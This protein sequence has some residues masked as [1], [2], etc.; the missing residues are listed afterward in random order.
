MQTALALRGN[1]RTF[2][3][4]FIGGGL[5]DDRYV[6]ETFR[7]LPNGEIA[8]CPDRRDEAE[9]AAQ[10]ARHD[11]AAEGDRSAANIRSGIRLYPEMESAH[12]CM[13]GRRFS[14]RSSR[15]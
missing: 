14:S 2:L 13:T 15:T 5:E 6:V 3:T 4:H 9:G 8:P 7:S 12:A 1:A 10:G 11:P